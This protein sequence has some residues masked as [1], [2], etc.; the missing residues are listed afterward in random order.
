MCFGCPPTCSSTSLMPVFFV[1]SLSLHQN[2]THVNR[3]SSG[4]I[5]TLTL[6]FSH[7]CRTDETEPLILPNY[8]VSLIIIVYLYLPLGWFIVLHFRNLCTVLISHAT[9]RIIVLQLHA[10]YSTMQDKL[11][12][13][14]FHYQINLKMFLQMK[15]I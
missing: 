2:I 5:K 14:N 6:L 7:W 13:L 8:F 9:Q 3:I 10:S 15:I 12:P 4:S 11:D 1:S